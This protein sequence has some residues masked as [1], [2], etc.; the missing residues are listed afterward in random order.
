MFFK[1]CEEN[2]NEKINKFSL[3][4][5][6]ADNIDEN[7]FLGYP[8]YHDSE[9]IYKNF[10]QE[11]DVN[12]EDISKIKLLNSTNALRWKY[13]DNENSEND[14]DIPDT[15]LDDLQE[16]ID[17]E[18]EQNNYCSLCGDDHEDLEEDQGE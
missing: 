6:Q 4:E 8:F 17:S 9:D 18:D 14:L 1:I 3:S 7:A 2:K 13:L 16:D 5:N 12:H 10:Q 15:E 11:E